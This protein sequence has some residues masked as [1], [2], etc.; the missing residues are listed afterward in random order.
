MLLTAASCS[1]IVQSLSFD[2]L[3][4]DSH[5]LFSSTNFEFWGYQRSNG[6]LYNISFDGGPFDQIDAY[7]ASA[8]GSDGPKQ[9]FVKTGL[10]NE[11]HSVRIVNVFDTRP[12]EPQFGQMNGGSQSL[13]LGRTM[14]LIL[15]AAP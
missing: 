1:G 15:S 12:P 7:N 14:R 4:P 6:A 3:S 8:S 2:M 5:V 9:L 10:S 13:W 11:M